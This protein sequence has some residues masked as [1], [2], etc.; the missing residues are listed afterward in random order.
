M[1]ARIL[2]LL[3]LALLLPAAAFAQTVAIYE[4]DAPILSEDARDR[5]QGARTAFR[6]VLVKA[7]GDTSVATAPEL[8]MLMSGLNAIV[9]G[10]ESRQVVENNA[11]GQPESRLV[12]R[13]RFDAEAIRKVLGQL[14]RPLWP[15][16]RPPMMVWLVVDDGT[17]KQIASSTQVQALGALTARA[18]ERGLTVQLP[19][20]DNVDQGRVDAVTLWD[21]PLKAV[22]GASGR[23]GINTSL[24]IRLRRAGTEWSAKYALIQGGQFEEW[25]AVDSSSAPLLSLGIDGAADRLARRFAFDNSEPPIGTISVW[26][27][28]VKDGA[29]YA[30]ALGYLRRLDVVK[31]IDVIGAEGDRAWLSLNIQAGPKRFKQLLKF[32]QRMNL[33][34]L[35]VEAG[36]PPAY[37]LELLP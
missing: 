12:L 36:Q 2:F 8:E 34:E 3:V 11:V 15:E 26:L 23:Y 7:S 31:Q 35:P 5:D 18:D 17:R 30:R 28:Q 22:V 37:A 21:A 4:A 24:L 13:V 6:R 33:L 9:T 10:E 14:G 16:Q 19:N 27:T 29:D 20:M 25:S 1:Y 32:D